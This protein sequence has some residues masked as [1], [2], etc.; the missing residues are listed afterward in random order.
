M[1]KSHS[2][3][4]IK[5]PTSTAEALSEYLAKDT[6]RSIT[7]NVIKVCFFRRLSVIPGK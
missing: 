2:A 5:T 6:K 3:T 4:D 7:I 1:F